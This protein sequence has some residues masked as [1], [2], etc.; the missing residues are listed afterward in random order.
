[1]RFE[2]ALFQPHK[3]PEDVALLEDAAPN[4]ALSAPEGGMPGGV[5]G[6]TLGAAGVLPFLEQPPVVKP[7]VVGGRVQSARLLKQVTPVYPPEAVEQ[8]LGGIVAL[9]AII[10]RDGSI[11][12]L[13]LISGHPLL[14]TA[15]IEAVEQWRYKPTVLNGVAVEVQTNIEV[16]FNLLE[17]PEPPADP[18]QQK[19]GRR[20]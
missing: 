19:K 1:M 10:A 12:Q 2:E 7:I 11:K 17:P 16:R 6:G 20:R 18:K 8:R 9:Q 4:V 14:A 15:A 3:I 5:F 13:V